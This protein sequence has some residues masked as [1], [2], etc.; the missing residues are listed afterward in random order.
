MRLI[1]TETLLLEEFPGDFNSRYAILSH[2]WEDDE[3]SFQEMLVATRTDGL[4]GLAIRKKAGFRKISE[5]ARVAAGHGFKYV[6][7]DTCCIDKTS[8]AELSESINSMFRWYSKAA[9][10][11]VYLADVPPGCM[12]DVRDALDHNVVYNPD[13]RVTGSRPWAQRQLRKLAWPSRG[14]I[15]HPF[16][17]SRWFTRGWTL[18]E[19]IAPV[20]LIF[21]YSDWT[22]GITKA[23]RTYVLYRITGIPESVLEA[24]DCSVVSIADRM[25]WA[26]ARTT[27]RV[28][29][30]AYCL[31][32]I[33]DVTMPMLYGE[34]EK[35]FLRLQEEICKSSDDHSL[36]AWRQRDSDKDWS[37]ANSHAPI[38]RGLFARS[39]DEFAINSV[40]LAPVEPGTEFIPPFGSTSIGFNAQ[41]PLIPLS[42]ASKLSGIVPLLDPTAQDSKNEFLAVLNAKAL[43]SWHKP[44][45]RDLPGHRVAIL[46]K[47]LSP[48][49]STRQYVRVKPSTVYTL[50]GRNDQLPSPVSLYVRHMIR[51][52]E[53]HVSKRWG[54]FVIDAN[55]R[56][57]FS[58]PLKVWS[59][60]HP[61]SD[62]NPPS[63]STVIRSPGPERFADTEGVELVIAS[64]DEQLPFVAFLGRSKDAGSPMFWLLKEMVPDPKA[65]N[66]SR[67]KAQKGIKVGDD[68]PQRHF[69]FEEKPVSMWFTISWLPKLLDDMLVCSFS[70]RSVWLSPENQ[71]MASNGGI[72]RRE[73]T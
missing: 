73:T 68:P 8:S 47:A 4:P 14:A 16:Y 5:F 31:L 11:Y 25:R 56:L 7:A 26:C 45:M 2:T 42:D 21:Y 29:D 63:N 30:M 70:I 15:D 41:F 60:Y 36:F 55:N 66:F 40:S 38:Y 6:W 49:A 52:P 48:G 51:I 39:P 3:I 28:E 22:P 46:L 61:G 44:G 64:T 23:S 1:N 54:G 58:A 59:P 50:T 71:H 57:N 72:L 69:K 67:L 24:G 27:T 13:Q 37:G 12:S 35:A 32:G 53:N 20:D 10:C 65:F 34:C 33:F 62:L 17:Q 43:A 18:Q 9:R 19:L